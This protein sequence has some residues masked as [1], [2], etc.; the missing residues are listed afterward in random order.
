MSR[1]RTIRFASSAP[2][3]EHVKRIT[4]EYLGGWVLRSIARAGVVC[5][6][7]NAASTC[8]VAIAHPQC[9]Q[10]LVRDEERQDTGY[11]FVRGLE[12]FV[13]G[14]RIDIVTRVADPATNALA[15][16]LAV[17]IARLCDGQ[18][19]PDEHLKPLAD[20]GAKMAAQDNRHTAE[21]I[22]V[23]QRRVR[24][25][26]YEQGWADDFCWVDA[27]ECDDISDPDRIAAIEQIV[28]TEGEPPDGVRRV[29]YR[30]RW[31]FVQPFFTEA[32][33]RRYLEDNRH[34]LE[35]PEPPRIYVESAW[36]NCEWKAIRR[37]AMSY[38]SADDG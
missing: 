27:E 11:H 24:D 3:V 36:R 9:S 23:V 33:A 38:V 26:G 18:C 29:G 25:W 22:F 10:A 17:V 13:F 7:L 4:D 30:D 35:G 8:P 28:A 6:D 32:A 15:G 37:I 34:N 19:E 1:D 20:M 12:V 31:E 5:V 16:G 21:P 14:D 2:S